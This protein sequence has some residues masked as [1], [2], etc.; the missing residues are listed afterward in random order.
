MKI[1][2]YNTK[3]IEAMTKGVGMKKSNLIR[4]RR[5]VYSQGS[6]LENKFEKLKLNKGNLEQEYRILL[7]G[8][9]QS[10]SLSGKDVNPLWEKYGALFSEGERESSI[11]SIFTT[12]SKGVSQYGQLF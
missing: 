4:R 7:N 8:E 9:G 5:N 6:K 1:L 3:V 10:G 11:C 12:E 2:S